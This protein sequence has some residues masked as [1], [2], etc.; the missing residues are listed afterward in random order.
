MMALR[1]VDLS[2]DLI[3]EHRLAFDTR[4]LVADILVDH[5]DNRLL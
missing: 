3:H 1:T 4:L 2:A 5:D